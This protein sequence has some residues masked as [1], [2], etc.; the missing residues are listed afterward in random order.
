MTNDVPDPTKLP[1]PPDLPA[2]PT[3][4]HPGVDDIQDLIEGDDAEAIEGG[5]DL[6]R[7]FHVPILA[8]A[9][10]AADSWRHKLNIIELTQDHSAPELSE[11]ATDFLR[12]PEVSWDERTE[13][14][15]AISLTHI[16]Q[17]LDE[18]LD[19]YTSYHNDRDLLRRRVDETLGLLGL[20]RETAPTAPPTPP[21][22]P[23]TGTPDRRLITAILDGR[24]D[25]FRRAL[26]DGAD[27]R[28]VID[29]GDYA[30]VSAAMAA[31]MR[32]RY[33]WARELVERGAD[34]HHRRTG[35]RPEHRDRGQTMV[36]WA[37][38]H[39]RLDMV[40]WLADR[41]ADIDVPD[42]WGSTPLHQAASAGHLDIVQWLVHN[43]ADTM[44]EIY[45]RRTPFNLAATHVRTDV[46]RW[47][48]SQGH[49]P[50]QVGAAGYTALMIACENGKI[51]MAGALIDAGADVNARH[52]GQGIYAG[53]RGWTPLV[54]CVRGG[55]IK[56]TR[57][58][59]SRGARV[60]DVIT[61]GAPGGGSEKR[62]IHFCHGRQAAKLAALVVDA[63]ARPA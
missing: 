26:A 31:C 21:A 8:R 14:A 55:R 28:T 30:T 36:W 38:G 53:L 62:V 63:G 57:Y 56:I 24:E 2:P 11:I 7:A 22:P 27:P 41:G 43:G 19:D 15:K 50:D 3:I 61:V 59:I 51:E 33:E 6:V 12:A 29:Q 10:W 44:A 4:D 39:G 16:G 32:E 46:V 18:D 54:F 60:D 23:L 13:L 17:E 40:E 45:D 1:A 37:A 5:R 49:P 20:E 25:E 35:P 48:L 34:V 58:L 9:Y 47:F 52:P 42:S